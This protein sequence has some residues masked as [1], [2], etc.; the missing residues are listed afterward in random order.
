LLEEIEAIQK[1][2]AEAVADLEAWRELA[3][4][5]VTPEALALTDEE[6]VRMVHELR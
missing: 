6:I 4:K 1:R 5:T 3:R 2:R